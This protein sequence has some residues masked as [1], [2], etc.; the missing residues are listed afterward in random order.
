[1]KSHQGV[2]SVVAADGGDLGEKEVASLFDGTFPGWKMAGKRILVII[3][4]TTRTC[5]LPMLFRLIC[6]R[7]TPLAKALN[8]LVA[9]GTHPPL[10]DEEICRLVGITDDQRRR[11]YASVGLFNHLWKTPGEL[12][13]AG[14]LKA[15]EVS[16]ITKGLFKMD[17]IITCNKMVMEHDLVLILGP[18][19]PHEVVGF[20][21]GNKYLFPGVAGKE[22][23][24]FFH[25][26]GAVITNPEIIGTKMTPVRQ[27]VDRAAALLPVE[28]KAVCLVVKPVI[29]K[30][31]KSGGSG[32]AGVY[33]GS[34]E[35]AWSAAADLSAGLHVRQ[36]GRQ[37]NTI[38][39]CAPVMYDDLWTGGKCMY[40][41]EPIA[42]AGGR[43]IIYAPHITEISRTHGKVL[44]EVG[45]HTRDFFLKQWD[46][47][48][49]YPWG[50]LAH[51]THVKGTGTYE[52][53]IE[54]PRVEVI[55]AT[56]IPE[57]ICRQVNLGYMDHKKIDYHDYEGREKEG[58]LYIPKAGEILYRV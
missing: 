28:R 26:L 22:I 15:A 38:L 35:D 8:F 19:F 46:K 18:V 57:K 37:F 54:K 31:A 47:Y 20:S 5:P 12:V 4:D 45:Y 25:W 27:V 51:S 43:V 33:C 48:K 30:T 11:D 50:V 9:L 23:I 52:N 17:V 55:L 41:V 21:G 44:L 39:S 36:M 34:P 29:E 2:K 24:D 14:L 49:G 16:A 1:M 7:L 56:G 58:I 10:S 13:E 53:G 32:L 42:A 6:E 40:K 3:P